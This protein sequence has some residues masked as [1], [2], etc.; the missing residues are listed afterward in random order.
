MA[1]MIPRKKARVKKS[2]IPPRDTLTEQQR[3]EIEEAFDILDTDGSGRIDA[4]DL[5]VA[6]RALGFEPRKDEVKKL[7]SDNDKENTGTIT[8]Q[9]FVE[10]FR[11]KWGETDSQDLLHLAFQ[12]YDTEDTGMLTLDDLITVTETIGEAATREELQEMMNEAFGVKPGE[13]DAYEIT[14]E[15]FY[16]IMERKTAT[17]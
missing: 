3:K 8:K 5:L 17:A 1:T 2:K 11:A 4:G 7:M 6:L 13:Q 9:Q 12:L 15:Q 14:E 10:I 16:Q